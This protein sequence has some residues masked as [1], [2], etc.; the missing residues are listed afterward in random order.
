[1]P[2]NNEKTALASEIDVTSVNGS[3]ETPQQP[4][5][6][7]GSMIRTL[8]GIA[9]LSGFLVVLVYQLTKPMIEENQRRAIEKAVFQVVPGAISRRDFLVTEDG[10]KPFEK[11]GEG[12]VVYPG[13]D[14]EG[15]LK[16]V[17]ARAGAQGYADM[18]YLLFGYD[19]DCQ[20]VRG[21][22]VLKMAETPGLGDKIIFDPEFLKNFEAL[23]ARLNDEGSALAHP[24]VPVK[25]GT[26]QNPWQIDAISGATVSSKAVAK[27]LDQALQALLPQLAPVIEELKTAA[28]PPETV[29]PSAQRELKE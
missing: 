22:K 9:A 11:G 10:L 14:A 4:P 7:A 21:I 6:A 1:M 28:P 25:H 12:I 19:P 17:A 8:A 13:Y 29:E 20:C 26:K 18:I 27:A 2:V 23:D 5:T 15:S 24:I 3:P 16:G